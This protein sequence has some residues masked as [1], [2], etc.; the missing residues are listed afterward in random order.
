VRRY[1]EVLEEVEVAD[2]SV[3]ETP[4]ASFVWRGR[5][6]LHT[7]TTFERWVTL[8]EWW[9]EEIDPEVDL[10]IRHYVIE[11][12][13][14]GAPPGTGLGV[15]EISCDMAGQGRPGV[16]ARGRARLIRPPGRGEVLRPSETRR[17][18]EC[19]ASDRAVGDSTPGENRGA[20]SW[21]VEVM[22]GNGQFPVR[23]GRAGGR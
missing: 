21:P 7:G 4:P 18:R 22:A 20:E 23:S 8:H 6:Y 2:V 3:I 13:R 14:E 16:H 1:D 10:E 5:R 17:D 19:V 15:V 12:W 9:R 11:V